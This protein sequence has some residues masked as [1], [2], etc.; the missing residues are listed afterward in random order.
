MGLVLQCCNSTTKR[1]PQN[2]TSRESLIFSARKR[3]FGGRTQNVTVHL[4]ELTGLIVRSH[5]F[6]V[7]LAYSEYYCEDKDTL[8]LSTYIND[9]EESYDIPRGCSVDKFK[10]IWNVINYIVTL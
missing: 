3:N 8:C 5:Q 4:E 10:S 2:G 9:A 1:I 7:H 6:V